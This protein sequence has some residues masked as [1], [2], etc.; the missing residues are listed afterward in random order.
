M[1]RSVTESRHT[2]GRRKTVYRIE[3]IVIALAIF[4][5]FVYALGWLRL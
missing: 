4:L 5:M 1:Y 2:A 3:G